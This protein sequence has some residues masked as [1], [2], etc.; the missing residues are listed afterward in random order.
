MNSAIDL[1]IK[2][3]RRTVRARIKPFIAIL[4]QADGTFY[5][6]EAGRYW[7]R[8]RGTKDANGNATHGQSFKVWAGE[9]NYLPQAG[10]SVYV[11]AGLNGKL[12]VLGA[13]PED[14]AEAGF[15]QRTF[16]PNDLYRHYVYTPNIV[17][18]RSDALADEGNDTLK[19]NLNQLF[20]KDAYGQIT[21]WNGTDENTHLDLAD[22]ATVTID[23]HQ[24]ALI[25]LR[26]LENEPAVYVST[27][28]SAFV[29]LD[30][31]DIQ[32][33]ISKADPECIDS[34]V[35][36]LY[37]NQTTLVANPET[38]L[39]VRQWV[40]VPARFG[41]PTI[42]TERLR[43]RAG[44]QVIYY[45]EAPLIL[46]E[47]QMLGEGVLLGDPS[48]DSAGSDAHYVTTQA[49]SGLPNE[50]NLGAL[51]SG[52]LKQTVAGSVST[53]AIA[54]AGTD[55]TTP[56]GTENLSNKTITASTLNSSPVG[57]VSPS[58]GNFTTLTAELA[59][60]GQTTTPTAKAMIGGNSAFASW[61]NTGRNFVVEANTLTDNTG[62]G[63]IARRVASSIGPPTFAAGSSETIT[64]AANLSIIGAPIAG[65]NV[66]LTKTVA[67]LVETGAAA[68]VAQIIRAAASQTANLLEI[69][70]SSATILTNVTSGGRWD[71]GNVNS[72]AQ[73]VNVFGSSVGTNM[74]MS[75]QG[76]GI[77]NG[78]GHLILQMNAMTG[79]VYALRANVDSTAEG[80]FAIQQAGNGNATF[81]NRVIGTGDAKTIFEKNGGQA[82]SMGYDQSDSG[83]FKI[84]SHANLGQN[85]RIVMDI[86]GA[87]Q[88]NRVTSGTNAVVDVMTFHH[89]SSGTPAAGFG[90]G[91]VTNLESSTTL[92]RRASIIE[93]LWNTATDS[94]AIADL[95]LS[96][97]YNASGGNT[98][99][100]GLRIR[101]DTGAVKMSVFGMP[102]VA[103]QTMGAATAGATYT[104]T[105]QAMI[106]A[107]YDAVRNFGIGT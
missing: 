32:E 57:A 97:Y 67:L 82:W 105:E 54:T 49:E 53:P 6:D 48:A 90:A 87:T 59:G 14:L 51:A 2:R 66:T 85:D 33:C 41:N 11:G 62:S 104:A 13:V 106:Q 101:G 25:T 21:R 76:N 52:I 65:T 22:Y 83:R 17:T 56:T 8:F 71:I 44:Q 107:V 29:D 24:Y 16:N 4:G 31:D 27:P 9:S 58:T 63:T 81:L 60:F 10:R 35:W 89:E 70:N 47:L 23:E 64:L 73:M 34:R 36:R 15:D 84:S 12:T 38:D 45:G 40:N 91:M 98:K 88:L 68:S 80:Y 102:V 86:D 96:A 94:G 5:C 100:E 103:Q 78:G 92:N 93:T 43:V 61:T 79:T 72:G 30:F 28:K 39:D 37:Y 99:R 26:T 55:Y 95:V 74:V 77:T 50:F 1:I 19:V 3:K 20:Y 46:G 42:I 69:Q 7:A 18:F 75:I